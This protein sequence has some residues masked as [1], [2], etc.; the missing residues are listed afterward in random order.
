M[1]QRKGTGVK[2][3]NNFARTLRN[4]YKCEKYLE[5]VKENKTAEN[6]NPKNNPRL[7]PTDPIKGIF[8]VNKNHAK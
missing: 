8:R 4:Y 6:E 5:P 1:E 2:D 3:W 7:P